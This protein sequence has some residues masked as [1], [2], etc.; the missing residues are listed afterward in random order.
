MDAEKV[1]QDAYAAF[2][3]GDLPVFLGLLDPQVEWF[4][5][6]H[7]VYWTGDPCIGP[8]QVVEQVLVPI[9]QDFDGFRIDISRMVA[10]GS[11]VLAG[12]PLRGDG[13]IHRAAAGRGG[14]A[15][16]GCPGR[17]GRPVP[18]VCRHAASRPGHRPSPGSVSAA[19][20]HSPERRGRA[21]FAM[22]LAHQAA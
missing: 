17:Q 18:P 4:E 9:Q 1:V 16:L 8:E 22:D 3:A 12:G 11:T 15:R 7:S 13:Q 20:P 2:A 14:R 19:P 5:A 6:E 10:D 21:A